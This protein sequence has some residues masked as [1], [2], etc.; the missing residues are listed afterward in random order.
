[1][2][3]IN[4]P[5]PQRVNTIY[6]PNP[7]LND[8]KKLTVEQI[9]KRNLNHEIITYVKRNLSRQYTWQFLLS[10]SKKWELFYFL[11]EH[12]DKQ[13]QVVNHFDKLIVGYVMSSTPI[14]THE[15]KADFR[16]NMY[17]NLSGGD[18]FTEEL[19]S[20]TIDFVGVQL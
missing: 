14:F 8:S 7:S 2:F 1:M 5:Y 16:S 10:L 15:R 11:R 6:L 13:M 17:D 19:V 12:N 9:Q 18:K 4:A 20:I 3:V